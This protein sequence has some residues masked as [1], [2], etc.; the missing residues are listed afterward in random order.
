[1]PPRPASGER[2]DR[3]RRLARGPEERRRDV[4]EA[5]DEADG[6]AREDAPEV[7]PPDERVPEP[8]G[9]EPRPGDEQ[10]GVAPPEVGLEGEV[11][12]ADEKGRGKAVAEA[13][14][15]GPVENAGRHA[16]SGGREGGTRAARAKTVDREADGA[17]LV[18]APESQ[19]PPG[20]IEPCDGERDRQDE[21]EDL[22]NL[23]AKRR[24]AF[25]HLCRLAPRRDQLEVDGAALAGRRRRPS[26]RRPVSREPSLSS[27]RGSRTEPEEAT[28]PRTARTP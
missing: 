22:G 24:R 17:C 15:E 13:F 1:M 5:E 28:P 4:L 19:V 20:E 26:G 16:R 8:A 6:E 9:E 10:L 11:D 18:P 12:D 25:R 7:V 14:P 21:E 3:N 27:P 2:I 23:R